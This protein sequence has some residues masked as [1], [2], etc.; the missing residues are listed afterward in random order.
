M[1][2]TTIHNNNQSFS[3]TVIQQIRNSANIEKA[4]YPER[5]TNPELNKFTTSNLNMILRDNIL[6]GKYFNKIKSTARTI[7]LSRELN[8][9]YRFKPELLASDE[10]G[11][12]G[13]WYVILKLNGCE[14]F[15]E[16]HDLQYVIVPDL[17]TITQC[18]LDEEYIL[19]KE[20]L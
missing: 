6:I 18:I 12:P 15:S 10:F 16:F 4:S 13:L 2:L 17:H 3:S 9:R 11:M 7:T 14:D 8:I 1:N 5:Y 19:E 20:V